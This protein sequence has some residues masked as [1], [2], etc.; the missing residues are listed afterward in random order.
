MAAKSVIS[1]FPV[2]MASSPGLEKEALIWSHILVCKFRPVT[3][4]CGS[5]LVLNLYLRNLALLD[6]VISTLYLEK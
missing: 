2:D 1:N 3:E 5:I 4:M 6:I